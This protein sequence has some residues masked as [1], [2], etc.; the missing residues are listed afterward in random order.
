MY[1]DAED[2]GSS[3]TAQC[4]PLHP[5]SRPSF[6]CLSEG[7]SGV[8]PAASGDMRGGDSPG[9]PGEAPSPG[10]FTGQKPLKPPRSY[11]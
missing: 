3:V 6:R 9:Q 4:Q 2:L 10:S 1:Q 5:L 11:K 7:D 8:S